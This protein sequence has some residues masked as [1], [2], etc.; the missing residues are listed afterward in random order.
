MMQKRALAGWVVLVLTPMV[1]FGQAPNAANI[2]RRPR[3][4]DHFTVRTF[5]ESGKGVVR[6]SEVLVLGTDSRRLSCF[7]GLAA[8][9]YAGVTDEHYLGLTPIGAVAAFLDAEMSTVGGGPGVGL[10]WYPW[11]GTAIRIRWSLL[12]QRLDMATITIP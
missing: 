10:N 8:I 3:F 1:T 6:Q 7:A 4:E 2:L 9:P 12:Q 11:E 5:A